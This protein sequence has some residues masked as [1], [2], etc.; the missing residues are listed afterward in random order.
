MKRVV[1]DMDPGVDDAVVLLL[2][3]NEPGLEVAAI[4]TVS[5]NVSLTK[6]TKNALRILHALGRT[7][8]VYM[9]ASRSSTPGRV[10]RAESAH[11]ADGLGNSGLESSIRGPEKTRAS[12]MLIELLKSSKRREIHLI[13]TGPLTNIAELFHKDLSLAKKLAGIFVMGGL[14][15]PRVKGNVTELAEFNFYSD[16]VSAD[17]VMRTCNAG[18][19]ILTTAGLEV[20]SLPEC[21]VTAGSLAAIRKIGSKTSDLACKIL[22][23]PVRAYSYFNLHDVFALAAM[24]HPELFVSETCS[25]KVSRDGILRG[26]CMVEPGGGGINICRKVN[27]PKFNKFLLD[28]LI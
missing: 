9:G 20:T 5:G 3:L 23:W 10:L 18:A 8:P 6:G 14:Y 19:P 16:P 28:G 26:S 7:E 11:G 1:L 2:A 13:A 22:E 21:A 15:D 12:D 27:E 24:L 25:V 17:L 4:T